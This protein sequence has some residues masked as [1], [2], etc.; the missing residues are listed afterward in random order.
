MTVPLP[1]TLPATPIPQPSRFGKGSGN[2]R[3]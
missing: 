2:P 1:G 3:R